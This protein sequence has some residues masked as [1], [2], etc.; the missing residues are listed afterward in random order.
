MNIII[1][2]L[3][4]SDKISSGI[5]EML[6]RYGVEFEIVPSENLSPAQLKIYK[7]VME[8]FPATSHEAALDAALTGGINWNFM[9][10]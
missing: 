6:H 4:Q 8:N 1:K 7:S 3:E 10:K 2:N 9:V 5:I